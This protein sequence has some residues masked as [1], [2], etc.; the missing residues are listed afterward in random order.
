M[1]AFVAVDPYVEV[2]GVDLSRWVA[3]VRW[4]EQVAENVTTGVHLFDETVSAGVRSG[5]LS[6]D[7]LVSYDSGSVY[8]TLRALSGQLATVTA[9]PSRS[10][11]RGLRNQDRSARFFVSSSPLL[12]ASRGELTV[13]T[14]TW[15]RSGPTTTT[16][17]AYWQSVMTAGSQSPAG[18]VR[19]VGWE[20][21]G[22]PNTPYG[23]IDD[24]ALTAPDGSDVTVTGIA[25]SRGYQYLSCWFATNAQAQAMRGAAVEAGPLVL[26]FDTDPGTDTFF[27]HQRVLPDPGWKT[28][29]RVPVSFWV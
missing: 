14:T 12:D 23:S 9:R 13:V 17:E 20:A 29:D 16:P 27:R 18:T 22:E 7:W 15:R 26:E 21:N 24:A 6:V 11:G 4:D 10:E 1:S 19:A 5:S 3:S 8:H 25:Y 2:N 28:G